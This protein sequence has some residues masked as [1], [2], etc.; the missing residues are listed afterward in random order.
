VPAGADVFDG[1]AKVGV[2]PLEVEVEEGR[3]ADFRFA[4]PG[5]RTLSRRVQAS[6]GVVEVRLA[7]AVRAARAVPSAMEENPYGKVDDLKDPFAAP[8]TSDDLKDPF[9]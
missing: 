1:R 2:T 5:Y 6:D 9:R 7:R 8:E 4:R 3:A